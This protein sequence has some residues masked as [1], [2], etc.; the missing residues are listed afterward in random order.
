M[1]GRFLG[2]MAVAAVVAAAAA[3]VGTAPS[4]EAATRGRLLSAAYSNGIVFRIS[5]ENMAR[6][7]WNRRPTT[8]SR[9]VVTAE[10]G[11]ATVG[12]RRYAYSASISWT[13]RTTATGRV[14][15]G[16]G[17]LNPTRQSVRF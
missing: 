13:S 8:N 7:T 15:V 2:T 5:G 17:I 1:G 3:A 16:G 14:T 4:A 10:S 9:G 12:R 11:T 6:A